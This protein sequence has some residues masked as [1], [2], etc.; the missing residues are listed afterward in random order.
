MQNVSFVSMTSVDGAH[1]YRIL[2]YVSLRRTHTHTH[3]HTYAHTLSVISHRHTQADR[4]EHQ[5]MSA[6]RFVSHGGSHRWHR[7]SWENTQAYISTLN[8]CVCVF[9]RTHAWQCEHVCIVRG[10]RWVSEWKWLPRSGGALYS[11]W[12]T[13]FTSVFSVSALC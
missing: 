2:Y 13:V 11:P 1:L 4:W 12:I 10:V 7:L 5:M 8:V 6:T 3:T 9:V